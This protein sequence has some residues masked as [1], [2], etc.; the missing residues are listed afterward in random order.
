MPSRSVD[1]PGSRTTARWAVRVVVIGA[2][3]LT[4][5]F[6]GPK[7]AA[8]LA[9]RIDAASRQSPAVVLDRAG[10]A[11]QPDWMDRPLLLAVTASLSPWLA[12]EVAI[13]DDVAQRQLRDALAAVPWVR[14]VG[15][16]RVFPDRLRLRCE[17]RR[18]VLAVRDAEGR[19]LCLV[20]GDALA[21][22]WV[23][24][25]SVPVTF[26]HH[27]GGAGTMKVAPGAPVTEPRVRAAAAIAVEWRD[28]LAPLVKG[29]P[30]LLE[31]DTTNLGERWLRGPSYPEVRV[32]LRREDGAGV[33]FA[34]DRPVDSPLPRVPVE[35]K[36][37]VLGNV[38]A[39]YPGLAGLVAGDLRF[40]RRWADY[41]QP[42]SGGVRDPNQ[43]WSDLPPVRGG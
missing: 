19:P 36:A 22:P 4:V 21:L 1:H 35:T 29:C 25:P 8:V 5:W 7:A 42:R 24:T 17:L 2:F 43:P 13:L 28:Q 37:T 14:T 34:Y 16:E 33:V 10:V 40:S 32:K 31:I 11:A 38:L 23:D 9:A 26:L 6:G 12:G 30:V 20:D 15:V 18:P 41:L 3:V 27:E 39:K